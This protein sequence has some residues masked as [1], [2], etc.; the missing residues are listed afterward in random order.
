[1][2]GGDSIL[3]TRENPIIKTLDTPEFHAIFSPELRVII[4]VFKSHNH[5]L[6]LAGGP[7]R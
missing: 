6:R 1:M 3:K 2:S 7:V 5:D 4:D